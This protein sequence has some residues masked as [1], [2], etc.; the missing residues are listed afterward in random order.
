[1]ANDTVLEQTQ[2]VY[3]DDGNVIETIDSQRFDNATGTGPLGTPT[4][5]VGARVYYAAAYYD[6]ADRLTADVDVG[7]NGGTAWTRPATPPA[8]SD[9]VLVTSYVYN[10]AGWVQD[11]IDPLGIDTRTMY[12]ALGRT[13]ETVAD[14][15]GNAGDGRVGRGHAVH[16]RRRQQR[17][18]GHGRRAGRRLPDDGLRL[19]RQHG[20]RQ[21]RQLQRHP[22]GGAVPRPDDRQPQQQPGRHATR[23]TRWAR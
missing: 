5:G 20:D 21:H 6:N 3:D 17:P 8:P 9:T 18:D 14:Y 16:L 2:T 11:V 23:S 10:A 7:T 19:R 22:G 15:T 4:S 13:T 1:M 12:D